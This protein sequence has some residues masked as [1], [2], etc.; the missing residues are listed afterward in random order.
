MLSERACLPLTS[1]TQL[2]PLATTKP[3]RLTSTI[4]MEAA[5]DLTTR[6]PPEVHRIWLEYVRSLP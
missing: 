2:P 6:L 3:P 5:R 1:L 4:K